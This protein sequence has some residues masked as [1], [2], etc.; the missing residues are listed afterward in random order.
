M[1]VSVPP[2]PHRALFALFVLFL[3]AYNIFRV[4]LF[5]MTQTG[6]VKPDHPL[7]P[8]FNAIVVY[9]ELAIGAVGLAA[10]PGLLGS[11][12]WAFWVTL[13]VS[14]YAIVF[15]G[16]SAVAVQLSAA[17][18]VIPPV[19]VLLFLLILR[20]RFLPASPKP[21]GASATQV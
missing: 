10:V 3:V 7:D 16:V 9:S 2:K 12:A 18:G 13:G 11:R 4:G 5:V 6:A 8:A 21:G 15:D 17:G 19:V 20:S 1:S 14:A